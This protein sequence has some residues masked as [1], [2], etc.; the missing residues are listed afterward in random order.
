MA[1]TNPKKTKDL[2]IHDLTPSEFQDVADEMKAT[3]ESTKP[4]AIVHVVQNSR[5]HTRLIAFLES[6]S[7]DGN[8]QALISEFQKWKKINPKSLP[9]NL[10]NAQTFAKL[11]EDFPDIPMEVLIECVH[12]IESARIRENK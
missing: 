3:G 9:M 6:I 1:E 11:Q 12:K 5:K 2:Y 4:E 8:V 10:R 7:I